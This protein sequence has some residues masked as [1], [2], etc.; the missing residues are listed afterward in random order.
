[1]TEIESAGEDQLVKK[2]GRENQDLK[3]EVDQNQ[4]KSLQ[5]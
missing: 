3:Q 1:M 4:K 5:N 2:R